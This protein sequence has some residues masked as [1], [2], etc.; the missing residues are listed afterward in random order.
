MAPRVNNAGILCLSVCAC[1]WAGCGIAP[2]THHWRSETIASSREGRLITCQTL[3]DGPR[4]ILILATIHGNEAA[5]T[6]L[7][8]RLGEYLGDHPEILSGKRVVLV[9]SV[10]VDGMALRQRHNARGIDLNRNFPARNFHET[11]RNGSRPLSEPESRAIFEL[12]ERYRPGR[13]VSIHQPLGCIDYD[14]PA[15]ALAR[16]MS[17]VSDLPVR[18]LGGRPG[19]LGSYVGEN[20]GIPTVTVELPAEASQFQPAELWDRYGAMLLKAI[21]YPPEIDSLSGLSSRRPQRASI[22]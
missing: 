14:G 18:K 19:S 21:T 10:N 17:R 5:G 11:R 9:P 2:G 13:V 3:G 12:L 16:A 22:P 20:L 8:E 6:P 15:H 7:L 4:S 1:L